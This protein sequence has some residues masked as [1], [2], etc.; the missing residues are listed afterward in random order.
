MQSLIFVTSKI[1]A[2]NSKQVYKTKMKDQ[3]QAK[4]PQSTDSKVKY[5]RTYLYSFGFTWK[6]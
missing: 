1:K 2:L 3:H 5:F 4:Q 6:D